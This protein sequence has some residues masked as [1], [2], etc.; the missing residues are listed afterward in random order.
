[1]EDA[2]GSI[3]DFSRAIELDPQY[4]NPYMSRG[5]AK[6]DLGDMHSGYQDLKMAAKLGNRGAMELLK[7]IG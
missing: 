1:M 4:S 5:I 7:E 3:A 6:C 2:E